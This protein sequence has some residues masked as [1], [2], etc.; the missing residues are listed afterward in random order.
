MPGHEY[1]HLA[2]EE[3]MKLLLTVTSP[4]IDCIVALCGATWQW[5]LQLNNACFQAAQGLCSSIW[6]HRYVG[7]WMKETVILK[8]FFFHYKHAERK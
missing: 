7:V 2:F 4:A 1:H 6:G 5:A 8:S 3:W